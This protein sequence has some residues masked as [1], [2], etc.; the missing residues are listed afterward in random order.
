MQIFSLVLGI[1]AMIGMVVGFLPCLGTFNWLNIPLAG[2][3]LIVS[4]VAYAT[5]REGSKT[6]SVIGLI[7][8]GIAILLGI[9]RLYMGG[10]VF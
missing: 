10:G 9:I 6:C 2:I 8:C 3:G 7:A 4:G 5:T 1:L